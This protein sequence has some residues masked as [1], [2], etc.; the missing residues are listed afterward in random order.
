MC[1]IL[2][3]C[4]IIGEKLSKCGKILD[5]TQ[6]LASWEKKE[7]KFII[8][9]SLQ[10]REC[11]GRKIRVVFEFQFQKIKGRIDLFFVEENQRIYGI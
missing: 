3:L 4:A 1:Q 10:A 8:E 7:E 11:E 9:A 5:E 6:L 2:N